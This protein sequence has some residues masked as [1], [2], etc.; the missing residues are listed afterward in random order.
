MKRI[1]LLLLVLLASA[2][3]SAGELREDR[4][5]P[6][7]GD[8][9]QRLDAL[10]S[11][12]A[13]TGFSG[14]VLV[15]QD[16]R[17]LV[18]KGYGF[19]DRQ[20]TRKITPETPFWIASISKQF[21]AAAILKL[22][23][24]G[25]LSLDDPITK[26]F[27]EVPEDKRAVTIHHLLSHKA[28]FQQ[29]YAADGITDRGEAVKAILRQ[30]LADPPG[31]GFTYANDNYNLLA[32]I[33]ESASGKTFESYLRESLFSPAGL[34]R[35][36]FWGETSAVPVAEI[37]G[38]VPETSLKPNWG[39]RGA[40]GISSTTGDLYR[41]YLALKD[42]KVL[43]RESRE[44]LFFPHEV[45]SPEVTSTYGWFLSPTPR[46]TRSVWTRG[47]ESF[48]HNAILVSYPEERPELRT[49][50]V[51]ASNAGDRDRVSAT[52][53]LAEEIAKIIFGS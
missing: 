42:D 29:K 15:V 35:T 11:E 34:T 12:A 49:V 18:D 37:P 22:A 19:A 53:R 2:C 30:P 38:E 10:L 44:K 41:W 39:F 14:S 20:R 16:G 25:R 5:D 45:V 33:V 51:A 40:T 28:G 24:Q 43:S 17:V 26:Y 6:S 52:R 47:T 48:G 1:I 50:I 31:K 21:T 23:E 27:P 7:E 36:G 8:L 4:P 3:Q 46:G 13:E 32:A 9:E